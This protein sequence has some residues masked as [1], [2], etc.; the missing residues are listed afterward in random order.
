MAYIAYMNVYVSTQIT[1]FIRSKAR[2]VRQESKPSFMV[3]LAALGAIERCMGCVS[4]C[5]DESFAA[6]VLCSGVVLERAQGLAPRASM[7]G[8]VKLL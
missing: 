2:W 1:L 7:Y 3:C 8:V 4:A 5:E 6:V